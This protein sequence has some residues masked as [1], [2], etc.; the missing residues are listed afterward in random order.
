MKK[1]ISTIVLCAFIAA[2]AM[3]QSLLDNGY[4]QR[5]IELQTQSQNAFDS[6]EYDQATELA[7]QAK[8][9]LGL[10]DQY[11]EKMLRMDAAKKIL[12][13]AKDRIDKAD[14]IGAATKFAD[15]FKTATDDYAQGTASFDSQD[16]DG[17]TSS[18]Q[19]VIDGLSGIE[20]RIAAYDNALEYLAQARQR[21]DWANSV[22][23]KLNYPDAFDTATTELSKAESAFTDASFDESID[24]SKAVMVAL[25]VV[26]ETI[27]LPAYYVV[28]RIPGKEDCYW[29]IA[30]YPFVYNNP[31]LW[32]KLYAANKAKMKHPDNPNL[33][34][35]GMIVK[36]PSVKGEVREG[37]WDA[38]K[39]YLPLQW[40]KKTK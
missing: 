10:S 23:A 25:A 1:I 26:Q 21:M 40:S 22:K 27:P 33:I 37:T 24:H 16:F 7:D 15:V 38:G 31:L 39:T 32:P 28:R 3:A 34:Y 8:Q 12:A 9:Y 20:D 19:A 14:S 29:R 13:V 18:A 2:S 6:G 30:A 36:I 17:A 35:P 11:V 4:Y 5:G